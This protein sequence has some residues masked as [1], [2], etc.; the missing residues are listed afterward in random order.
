MIPTT[1]F[2]LRSCRARV[3]KCYK[4]EIKAVNEFL[5]DLNLWGSC[6]VFVLRSL[7]KKDRGNVSVSKLV[8]QRLVMREGELTIIVTFGKRRWV[9]GCLVNIC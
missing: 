5:D 8:A 4:K 9:N 2:I 6:K 3:A 1:N 7:D